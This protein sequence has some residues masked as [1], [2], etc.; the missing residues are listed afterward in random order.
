MHSAGSDE[1]CLTDSI[2]L[3][4]MIRIAFCVFKDIQYNSIIFIICQYYLI[5]RKTM[6]NATKRPYRSHRRQEAAQRTRRKILEASRHLFATQGYATTTLPAIATEAE[7]AVATITAGF[8]TKLALLEAV[9]KWNV[10]GDELPIPLSER[11]WWQEV[12][13]EPDPRQRLALYAK[14][15]QQ[16]HQRTTDMFMIVRSAAAVEPTMAALR[17]ELGESHY[18]DDGKLVESLAKEGALAPG[19][20][21]KQATDLLWALGS[22]DLYQILIA[23]CGWRPEQY[24]QWLAAAWIHTL[25]EGQGIQ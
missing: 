12:L 13:K 16:I 6:S 7:V 2:D 18:E 8:G 19:V 14:N 4:F 11:S 15:V 17:R 21:E 5:T 9:V 22:A 25:L 1:L 23:D 10:R 24:A 20:A 3:F